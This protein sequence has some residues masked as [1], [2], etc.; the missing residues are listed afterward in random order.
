[1]KKILILT[2]LFLF[3]FSSSFGSETHFIDFTKVLNSSKAGSA[4]Q[5]K[6][7]EKFASSTKKFKNEEISLRKQETE[8]IAQKNILKKEEYKSKVESLRKKV[9]DLQKRKQTTFNNI[10]K[11]R[12]KAKEK[13]LANVNPILEKYM[14]ENKIILVLDAKAVVMGDIDY[15]ITE[16]IIKILNQKISS[17]EVK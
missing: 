9:T 7:Q 1:M 11:S 14:E 12:D 10:A 16:Q 4:F 17:L 5:K 15:D 13:L 2:F 3:Y 8:I 6:L